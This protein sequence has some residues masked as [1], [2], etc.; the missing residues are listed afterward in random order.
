MRI[1]HPHEKEPP[2]M[3]RHYSNNEK[4]NLEKMFLIVLLI[5]HRRYT[6]KM[7]A[8]MQSKTNDSLGLSFIAKNKYISKGSNGYT[9]KVSNYCFVSVLPV[10]YRCN[11][12]E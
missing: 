12:P 7:Y 9:F 2:Q 6:C 10:Y 4:W 3:M 1:S 5:V 11:R 8:C